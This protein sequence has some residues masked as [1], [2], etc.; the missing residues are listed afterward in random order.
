[1]TEG[2]P[3][4]RRDAFTEEPTAQIDFSLT[5]TR[6]TDADVLLHEEHEGASPT[7]VII[8]GDR[9]GS[10]Y[11]LHP[12]SL[13]V[14]RAEACD[15]TV[16]DH[17]ASRLHCQFE[18]R[19]DQTRVR[20][21]GSTNGTRVNEQRVDLRVLEDGDIIGVGSTLLKYLAG[22]NREAAY[23]EEVHRL[24]MTDP[25]TG[26]MNRRSFDADLARCWYDARRYDRP[27][28]LLLLDIDHFK[29]VNDTYGHQAGD[30]VLARLGALV[31]DMKRFSDRFCR[32]GGE[33]FA[34][35]LPQTS[36]SNAVILAERIRA[37]VEATRFEHEERAIP[38]TISIGAAE[39]AE[40]L[41]SHEDLVKLA[42]ERLYEAKRGGRNRTVPS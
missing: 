25:L 32:Y 16:V 7:L 6:E 38:V 31:A 30:R 2:G 35:L 26:A 4:E 40:P 23:F 13:R 19:P 3:E 24:M 12:G 34:L 11:A 39:V 28:S 17:A 21:L 5:P 41:D 10:H 29:R 18:T 33:E 22:S 14:G 1:M 27:F 8:S 36:L 15:I 20:D 42:D 9:I 37:R